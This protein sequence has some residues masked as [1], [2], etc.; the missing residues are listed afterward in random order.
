[1]SWLLTT[2]LLLLQQLP[3]PLSI[4]YSI[5]NIKLVIFLL[6]S[7][8][9]WMAVACAPR[10]TSIAE[11]V[12]EMTLAHYRVHDGWWSAALP[13]I[14]AHLNWMNLVWGKLTQI[15]VTPDIIY[16]FLVVN[17][18]QN[19]SLSESWPLRGCSW[20]GTHN[21]L[22]N[23]HTPLHSTQY[24][25]LCTVHTIIRQRTTPARRNS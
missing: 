20:I 7:Y 17:N 12:T 18:K 11:T 14:Q 6:C 22:L 16:C 4:F 1:M 3:F 9:A 15:S 25:A 13:H 21:S 2:C 19:I 23:T 10:R 8:P 5:I 24:T